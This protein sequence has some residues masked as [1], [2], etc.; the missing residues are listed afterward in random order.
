MVKITLDV[1]GMAC[2]MCEGHVNDT[3]RRA[4][5]VKKVMSSHTKGRTEILAEAPIDEER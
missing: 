1:E 5:P 2:S 3:V 4:F